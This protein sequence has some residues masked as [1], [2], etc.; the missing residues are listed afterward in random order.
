LAEVTEESHDTFQEAKGMAM[1]AT[2]Q[3]IA[4]W[5]LW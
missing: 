4:L 5:N 3:G 1:E 2:S